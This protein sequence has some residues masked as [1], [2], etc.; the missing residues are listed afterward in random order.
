MSQC[1]A[2]QIATRLA[3]LIQASSLF[4]VGGWH[5]LAHLPARESQSKVR[6]RRNGRPRRVWIRFTFFFSFFLSLFL[7]HSKRVFPRPLFRIH[8]GAQCHR[9]KI[10][11]N[12]IQRPFSPDLCVNFS[13]CFKR[14]NTVAF[15]IFI[16][17]FNWTL[18]HQLHH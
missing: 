4:F 13:N 10:Q 1:R 16:Q 7:F 12:K 3:K 17:G 8:D 18:F 14:L 2:V 6:E 5:C 9:F 11:G 15:F